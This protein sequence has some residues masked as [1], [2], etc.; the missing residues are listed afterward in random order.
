M[1]G[2]IGTLNTPAETTSSVNVSK[3]SSS[4]RQRSA[5]SSGSA[6]KEESTAW[7]IS[8]SRQGGIEAEGVGLGVGD[9]YG[10]G[11]GLGYGSGGGSFGRGEPFGD[12]GSTAFFETGATEG[13]APG[14]IESSSRDRKASITHPPATRPPARQ[15]PIASPAPSDGGKG[16]SKDGEAHQTKLFTRKRSIAA[17]RIFQYGAHAS[18]SSGR[19]G[20]YGPPT[21]RISIEFRANRSHRGRTVVSFPYSKSRR[22]RGRDQDQEIARSNERGPRSY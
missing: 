3:V 4:P 1:L 11:Y 21:Y 9:G 10:L 7:K 15:D 14:E 8:H 13:E 19:E 6:A 5:S 16:S 20:T 12:P 18:N 22:C 17:I 2:A